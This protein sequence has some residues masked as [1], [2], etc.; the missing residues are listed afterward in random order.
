MKKQ[1]KEKPKNLV[2]DRSDSGHGV[3][4]VTIGELNIGVP[5]IK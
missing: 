4:C 5:Y 2:D 1:R 3:F